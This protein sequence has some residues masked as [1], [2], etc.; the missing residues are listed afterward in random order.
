[1]E[2]IKFL[3]GEYERYWYIT[4]KRNTLCIICLL[5]LL[6]ACGKDADTSKE[7]SVTK[8]VQLT[9]P[10]TDS[11]IN[12]TE[13]VAEDNDIV[14]DE[15]SNQDIS[16]TNKNS[17]MHEDEET[18][19]ITNQ[20]YEKYKDF[21]FK[22][23]NADWS[24]LRDVL[25]NY[26]DE[27]SLYILDNG[28]SIKSSLACNSNV[29]RVTIQT[30]DSGD[31]LSKS[32]D[33]IERD[34]VDEDPIDYCVYDENYDMYIYRDAALDVFSCATMYRGNL[35]IKFNY[36]E[37]N[38]ALREE[39]EKAVLDVLYACFEQCNNLNIE[40]CIDDSDLQSLDKYYYLD[41]PLDSL[42]SVSKF[43]SFVYEKMNISTDNQYVYG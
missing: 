36:F 42:D 15:L 38:T 21:D 5:I 34:F 2:K 40:E 28:S 9:P 11:N 4:M 31:V 32:L 29:G 24:V 33:G 18:R 41:I 39:A 7:E 1:M 25:L 16:K 13:A 8:S 14:Y 6:T 30:L 22:N 17:D 23:V 12:R 20:T 43:D 37:P 35:C 27:E 3:T 10:T 19:L 26:Y